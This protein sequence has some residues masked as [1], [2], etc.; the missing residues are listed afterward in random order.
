MLT[1]IA[2]MNPAT[3]LAVVTDG[4]YPFLV[5]ICSSDV[6]ILARILGIYLRAH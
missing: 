2:K 1:D 3:D 4:E 5:D 6:H